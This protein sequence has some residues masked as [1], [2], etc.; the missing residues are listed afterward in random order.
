MTK[1]NKIITVTTKYIPI[2]FT[3]LSIILSK[4]RNKSYFDALVTIKSL[5]QKASN[6]IWKTLYAAASNATN[7]YK[8]DKNNL[9]ID[10][11]FV[12][13]GPILKRMQPRA[14]GKSYEIQKKMSHLTIKLR[15]I[16]N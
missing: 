10:S 4:I 7:N 5:P 2:S 9:Y 11:I 16:I 12:N 6:I 14:K 15:E 3:K 1:S 8:I 13:K